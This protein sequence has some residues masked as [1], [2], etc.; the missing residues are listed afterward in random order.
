[1]TKL[2]YPKHGLSPHCQ[3]KVAEC[4]ERLSNAANNCAFDIPS[5]FPHKGYLDGLGDRL[6]GYQNEANNIGAKITATD[7]SFQQLSDH[8]EARAGQIAPGKVVKRN[9]MIV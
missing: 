5:D 9:R 2:S 3:N 7:K 8:L 6:R 1:M 4:A